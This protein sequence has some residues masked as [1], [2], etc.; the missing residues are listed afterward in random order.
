M[1][2]K[3]LINKEIDIHQPIFSSHNNVYDAVCE[4]IQFKEKNDYSSIPFENVLNTV[5]YSE[6]RDPNFTEKNSVLNELQIYLP[7]HNP[8]LKNEYIKIVKNEKENELLN[9]IM[10]GTFFSLIYLLKKYRC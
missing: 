9:F 5:N 10:S 8:G 1:F 4:K 2:E 6:Q 3:N 7:S